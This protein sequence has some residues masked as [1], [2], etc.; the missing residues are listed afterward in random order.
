MRI[1]IV[2]ALAFLL[3]ACE[4]VSRAPTHT[5]KEVYRTGSNL[6]VRDRTQEN[7]TRAGEQAQPAPK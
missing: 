6:P 2:L 5:G 3:A 1:P 7:A 4:G